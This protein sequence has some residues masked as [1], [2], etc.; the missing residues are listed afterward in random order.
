MIS[1]INTFF[2]FCNWFSSYTYYKYDF[3]FLKT[4]WSLQNEQTEKL[5]FSASI[6]SVWGKSG[7]KSVF[8]STAYSTRDSTKYKWS[9]C[10]V[11]CALYIDIKVLLCIIDILCGKFETEFDLKYS[12]KFQIIIFSEPNRMVEMILNAYFVCLYVCL[13]QFRAT[14]TT[15]AEWTDTDTTYR[16]TATARNSIMCTECH[17][18][19]VSSY[20]FIL[21]V[22]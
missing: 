15:N 12:V 7:E 8:L 16:N 18:D 13:Q 4:H 9:S 11:H 21:S 10:W 14:S 22:N 2:L 1:L 20:L 17:A 5:E 6:Q 19:K 3:V